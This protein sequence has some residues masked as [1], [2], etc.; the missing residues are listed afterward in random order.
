MG[1]LFEKGPAAAAA[2]E[3]PASAPEAFDDTDVEVPA[4]EPDK[5]NKPKRMA[6]LAFVAVFGLVFVGSLAYLVLRRVN[7]PAPEVAAAPVPLPAPIP[8]PPAPKIEPP[9]VVDHPLAAQPQAPAPLAEP[10]ANRSYLQVGSL[11]KG[12]A[13]VLTQGL[14]IKGMSA[15]MAPGV[16]PLVSRIIVGPFQTQA[17]IDSATKHLNE[18]G[19]KPFPRRF[20]E[21]ELKKLFEEAAAAAA[22]AANDAGKPD[23][24]R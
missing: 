2:S 9:K 15:T 20:D 14:R 13:E 24:R 6:L 3:E 11:E 12:V 16:T 1:I 4:P 17:E 5:S 10:L 21:K 23:M 19:F 18:L 8:A 22:V 7:S